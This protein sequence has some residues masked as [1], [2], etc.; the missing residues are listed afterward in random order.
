M[1]MCIT[2][3]SEHTLAIAGGQNCT[4]HAQDGAYILAASMC[5][6]SYS[7]LEELGP[8]T[9]HFCILAGKAAEVFKKPNTQPERPR[10]DHLQTLE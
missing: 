10:N 9:R 1:Y 5:V 8:S 3:E 7:A 6:W 4:R 2:Y